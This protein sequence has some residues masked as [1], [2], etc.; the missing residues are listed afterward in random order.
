L[1][2]LDLSLSFQISRELLF[3]SNF[4]SSCEMAILVTPSALAA[5]DER[6]G[7]GARSAARVE[8]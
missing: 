1:I 5:I 8:S 4:S 3:F 2:L 7:G 6:G